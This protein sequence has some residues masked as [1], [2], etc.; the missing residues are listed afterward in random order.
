MCGRLLRLT[1]SS[2]AAVLE[3]ALG[4]SSVE[5]QGV[6]AADT[7]RV[8]RKVVNLGFGALDPG[9][10]LCS[11]QCSSVVRIRMCCGGKSSMRAHGRIRKL[12]KEEKAVLGDKANRHLNSEVNDAR[13][14]TKSNN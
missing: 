14:R 9:C 10:W 13:G 12:K 7:V 11:G 2:G 4:S 8:A 6:F 1:W 5:T 3:L